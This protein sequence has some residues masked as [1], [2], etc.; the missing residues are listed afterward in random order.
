MLQP[1]PASLQAQLANKQIPSVEKH[2]LT[3][4][5]VYQFATTDAEDPDEF[6]RTESMR[7]MCELRNLVDGTQKLGQQLKALS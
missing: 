7:K 6:R 1:I 5:F 2:R 3:E 4:D